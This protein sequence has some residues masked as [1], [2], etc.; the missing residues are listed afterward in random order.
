MSVSSQYPALRG[1]SDAAGWKPC[2]KTSRPECDFLALQI[3]CQRD[4]QLPISLHEEYVWTCV[5]FLRIGSV[6]RT[7]SQRRS[8]LRNAAKKNPF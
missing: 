7:H 2:L 4:L 5:A 3:Q 6:S 1:N 8:Y